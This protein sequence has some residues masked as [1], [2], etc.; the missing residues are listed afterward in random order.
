MGEMPRS[1]PRPSVAPASDAGQGIPEGPASGLMAWVPGLWVARHYKANWLLRDLAAGLVLTALLVPAGMGYAEAAGLPAITGLYATVGPLLAYAAFGPSRI[2]VLGPDSALAALIAAAITEKAAG[3]PERAVALASVLALFTGVFCV[4]AGL[5]RAGFVTDLL[6]KPVRVGYMNGMGI[7]VLVSQLPKLF[8]VA[9]G[10][11][12]TLG[13]AA[14]FVRAVASSETKPR[15]LIIGGMCLAVILVLRAVAPRVPGVLVAVVGATVAV[16]LL[17][18]SGHMAV[19]GAVPRGIPVPALPRVRFAELA[20]L[21]VAAAGIALVTFTDTSVLSRTYAAR[22]RFRVD[23]NRELVGLG[24]A[25]LAAGLLRGFPVSS[26]SSRTPVAESAG[27]RTQLTGVVGAL[28]IVA[29]LLAAPDLLQNLPVT[30]LSAVVISAALRVLDLGALRAFYKFRHSD[31]VLSLVALAG[32]LVFGALSGIALA[33][34]L[35]LLDFVRRAWRPHD[36]ILGRADGVKGYHDVRRYPNAKQI[37]G[38]LLFRWDAPL[39]FANAETFRERVVAAADEARSP[40]RWVVIA[41]EPITDVDTTAADMLEELDKELASRGAELA[42]AEMKDPVKDRLERYGLQKRIGRD[43]FFPT[44]GVAV[45]AFV[46]RY[47][48]TWTDWEEAGD[49]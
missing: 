39:F 31:F 4:G 8:G 27:S 17:G 37:P 14:H 10:G 32:V 49:G 24:V 46:A 26:S 48:A 6:S 2:L 36:A 28:A 47:A 34:T 21:A 7:S 9:G 20:D 19:V 5:A 18:E 1:E 42:F 3:D 30:A 44:I 23:P 29:L 40:V 25:N 41:A 22:N 45:K 13:T 35:S 11:G 15:V 12:S 33:V 16:T 38:L 43:F